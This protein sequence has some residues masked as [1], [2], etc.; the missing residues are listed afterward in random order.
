MKTTGLFFVF[1]R[2]EGTAKGG[3]LDPTAFCYGDIGTFTIYFALHVLNLEFF[4]TFFCFFSSQ[5]I[6]AI[7]PGLTQQK[8]TTRIIT[9]AFCLFC[10]L[11]SHSF[12]ARD[13]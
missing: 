1:L 9:P 8:V 2:F 4:H 11:Q 6:H 10:V 12:K 7:T 5:S 13:D 3:T